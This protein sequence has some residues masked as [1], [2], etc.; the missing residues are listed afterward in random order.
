MSGRKLSDPA[1]L[2]LVCVTHSDW[3]PTVTDMIMQWRNLVH[4]IDFLA[5][6]LFE[7]NSSW[8][9]QVQVFECLDY[10]TSYL[11]IAFVGRKKSY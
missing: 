8:K 4:C 5:V 6:S 1:H 2:H 7:G 3:M 11:I 10:K 9:I